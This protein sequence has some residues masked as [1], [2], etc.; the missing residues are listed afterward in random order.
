MINV[1]FFSKRRNILKRKEFESIMAAIIATGIMTVVCNETNDLNN[2]LE[3]KSLNHM[4]EE[5]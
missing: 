2:N 4:I 5:Y 1:L 3:I